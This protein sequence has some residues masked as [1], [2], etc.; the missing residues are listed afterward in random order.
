M[1]MRLTHRGLVKDGEVVAVTEREIF[2][3]IDLPYVE[4][5]ER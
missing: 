5:E 2:T 4:P 1:G 3:A